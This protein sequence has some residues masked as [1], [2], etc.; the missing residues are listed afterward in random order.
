MQG[1]NCERFDNRQVC[2]RPDIWAIFK[3]KVS[4]GFSGTSG[5]TGSTNTMNVALDSLRE[6]FSEEKGQRT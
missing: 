6:I 2:L 4:D 3:C 1:I 5:P